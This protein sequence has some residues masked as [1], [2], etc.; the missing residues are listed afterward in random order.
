MEGHDVGMG[1]GAKAAE[2]TC[3]CPQPHSLLANQW[4]LG[5]LWSQPE[6]ALPKPL[7]L[8][9]PGAHDLCFQAVR[10][11]PASAAGHQPGSVWSCSSF[12]SQGKPSLD[13]QPGPLA[14]LCWPSL[15]Q[16]N[17]CGG[18]GEVWENCLATQSGRLTAH[19]LPIPPTHCSRSWGWGSQHSP[20]FPGPAFRGS[21]HA[22]VR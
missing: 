22:C 4:Y 2:Q 1:E 8:P 5:R 9:C 13:G 15:M 21:V 16:G 19:L 7:C 14:S 20:T 11:S 10:T 3:T 17:G 6:G 12:P 18:W